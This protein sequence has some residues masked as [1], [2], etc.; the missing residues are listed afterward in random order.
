[1]SLVEVAKKHLQESPPSPCSKRTDLP[2]AAEQ[3]I[4]RALAKRPADRYAHAQDLATAF[5]LALAA[6]HTEL[7]HT[8]KGVQ[9]SSDITSSDSYS[10][11]GSFD[12]KWRTDL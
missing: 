6:R 2:L 7:A 10:P 1:E 4:L 8:Q 11:Y 12:P 9:L 3:V 5:R